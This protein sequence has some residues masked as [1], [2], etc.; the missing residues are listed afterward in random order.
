[1]AKTNHS[2]FNLKKLIPEE[3][4]KLLK[5]NNRRSELVQ[6]CLVLALE[7]KNGDM[8][9][10]DNLFF[11]LSSMIRYYM[12]LW[13]DNHP[14]DFDEIMNESYLIYINCLKV[15]N[16]EK[17]NNFISFFKMY[18]RN[19]YIN[20]LRRETMI[21]KKNVINMGELSEEEIDAVYS[22]QYD[23]SEDYEVEDLKENLEEAI[24]NEWRNNETDESIAE[25]F[26]INISLIDKIRKKIKYDLELEWGKVN[27]FLF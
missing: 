21:V 5:D 7:A 18:L 15:F 20:I 11:M 19:Q 4:Y 3:D 9:S 8:K 17:S 6:R 26:D 14:E 13:F 22:I 16:P 25:K 24:K 1:M 2:K 23:N 12:N 10:R 27:N